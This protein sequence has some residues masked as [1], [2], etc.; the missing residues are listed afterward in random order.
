MKRNVRGKSGDPTRGTWCTA[1]RV[2]RALGPF[3]LDPFSN[4]RSHIEATH[5]CMLEDGGDGFG[6]GSPGSYRMRDPNMGLVTLRAGENDRT[7]WQPP[8]E[9][10]F[11]ER[12]I[13]HY[14]HTRWTALLRFD[15]RTRWFRMLYRRAAFVLVLWQAEFEPPPGV[16]PSSNTFPHAIFYRRSEDVTH[17]V[18][19]LG[20]SWRTNNGS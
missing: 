13:R 18:L 12:V 2:A 14:G 7:F 15:P 10:G 11:V 6:D 17:D 8:F 16:K 1:E 3:D 19:R 5:R 4:P 20:F 9:N